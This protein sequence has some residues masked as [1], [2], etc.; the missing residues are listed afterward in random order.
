MGE[1]FPNQDFCVVDRTSFAVMQ[2]PGVEQVAAFDSH[3]AVYRYDRD[4]RRAF[5]IV[6]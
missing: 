4:R 1:A 3:F 5:T 6:S 2:R